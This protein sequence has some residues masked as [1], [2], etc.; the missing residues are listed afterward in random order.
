MLQFL[1]V[2]SEPLVNNWPCNPEKT[3]IA[4]IP[5]RNTIASYGSGYG[6]NSLLGK[7]CFALRLGS[8]LARDEG[9][10]AEHMLVGKTMCNLSLKTVLRIHIL[11]L[12]LQYFDPVT[13]NVQCTREISR[14]ELHVRHALLHWCPPAEII[15]PACRVGRFI[16]WR[17][18]P[19]VLSGLIC[20]G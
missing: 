12:V 6:G 17:F 14:T 18:N 7:K 11:L 15:S 20:P 1:P 19:L 5:D 8:I 2:F 4:H 10:L 13:G 3:L 16:Q 9:W